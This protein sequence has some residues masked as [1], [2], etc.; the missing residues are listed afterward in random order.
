LVW[1]SDQPKQTLLRWQSH[2]SWTRH[3]STIYCRTWSPSLLRF[4]TQPEVTH[5]PNHTHLLLPPA[6]YACSS[7][8]AWSG[9]NS[10]SCLSIY[11]IPPRLLQLSSGWT[12]DVNS[13]HKRSS[14]CLPQDIIT[15]TSSIPGRSSNRSASN[16]DV[17]VP[18]TRLKLGERAFSVAEPLAWNQLPT[19]LKIEKDTVL[20][21]CK[22]KTFLYKVA[23]PD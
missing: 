3:H 2:S 9:N 8:P 23:Y 6:A 7:Q 12:S 5:Q 19:E 21:K 15:T 20:F 11:I 13:D 1:V 10:A 18:R 14:T 4:R 17:V 22:M 16:N